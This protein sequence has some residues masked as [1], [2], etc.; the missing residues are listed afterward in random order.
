MIACCS[1]AW[2]CRLAET[3]KKGSSSFLKK[4]TKKPLFDWLT[5]QSPQCVPERV[6]VFWCFFS[7]K[8]CFLGA[9]P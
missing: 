4:S 3:A 9:W 7:K 2:G 6:K 1:R 8:N 5:R